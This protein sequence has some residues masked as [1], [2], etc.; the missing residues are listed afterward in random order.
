MWFH[1]I[2]C[3]FKI[4]LRISFNFVAFDF[5]YNS[6]LHV[7]EVDGWIRKLSRVQTCSVDITHFLFMC[8][9]V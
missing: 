9:N 3:S 7:L 2:P 5:D 4:Y 1:Q 8:L 6:V